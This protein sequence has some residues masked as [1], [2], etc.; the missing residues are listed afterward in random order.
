MLAQ[1]SQPSS[2]TLEPRISDSAAGIRGLMI[3]LK[4]T[5]YLSSK[6]YLNLVCTCICDCPYNSIPGV[7]S[8]WSLIM[9]PW[10]S[11]GGLIS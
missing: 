2:L 1:S 10:S 8:G 4:G 6:Y 3:H 7:N 9:L 5:G 11:T